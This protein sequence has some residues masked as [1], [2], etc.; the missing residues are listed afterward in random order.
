MAGKVVE[1]KEAA[2]QTT[3]YRRWA[4]PAAAAA[5]IIAIIAGVLLTLEPWVPRVESASEERM[6]FQ[7]PDKPSI[8]VLPFA[9]LSSDKSQDFLADGITEDIITDLSKISSLFVLGRNSTFK[10]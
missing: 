1:Q 7:L 4:I 5:V 6:A 10:Y 3:K 9:N 2:K 8:A